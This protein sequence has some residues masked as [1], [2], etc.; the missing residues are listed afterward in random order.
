MLYRTLMKMAFL[1]PMFNILLLLVGLLLLRWR[2][3][4]AWFCLLLS[5]ITLYLFSTPWVAD[6]LLASIERHPAIP[7]EQLP[8]LKQQ[9]SGTKTAIVV[10]GSGHDIAWPQY[11]D[12]QLDER[13]ITRAN[14][15]AWLSRQLELPLLLTGGSFGSV[16]KPHAKIMAAYMDRHLGVSPDWLEIQSRTTFENAKYAQGI[17]ERHAIEQIVLVTHSYHMRRSVNLFTE[18]GITI[19][20]API[21]TAQPKALS[22][23]EEW[24]PWPNKMRV[25]HSVIHEY[26]GLLYYSVRGLF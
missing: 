21:A 13:A 16:S 7:V 20:P 1:P 6:R 8:S 15:A 5:L 2:P 24:L 26:L 10:L 11:G 17:L 22:R 3:R 4:L 14:Y 25:S 19:I 9:L 12:Q 18:L 23:I